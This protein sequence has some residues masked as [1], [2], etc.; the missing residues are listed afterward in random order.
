MMSQ[1]HTNDRRALVETSAKASA[2]D[3]P[4]AESNLISCANQGLLFGIAALTCFAI[5]IGIV[6][7]IMSAAG[8]LVS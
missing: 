3:R 7:G 8:Y 5:L 6:Y 1:L 2:S 4:S